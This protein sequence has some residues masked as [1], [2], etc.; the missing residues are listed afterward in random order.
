MSGSPE[1]SPEASPA[2]P[3]PSAPAGQAGQTDP[4]RDLREVE[5]DAVSGEVVSLLDVRRPYEAAPA[6][7]VRAEDAVAAARS[8]AAMPDGLVSEQLLRISFDAAGAQTLVWSI[9]LVSPPGELGTA[10]VEVDAM[11]GEAAVLGQG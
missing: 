5:V 6:P 3:E 11:T 10:L 8:A 4:R 2:A 7:L 9:A 1:A